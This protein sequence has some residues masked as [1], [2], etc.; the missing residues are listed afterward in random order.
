MPQT[1]ASRNALIQRL[2][3]TPQTTQR[4]QWWTGR[5]R[6]RT[7]VAPT[8]RAHPCPSTA[9]T[10]HPDHCRRPISIRSPAGSLLG[11]PQIAPQTSTGAPIRTQCNETRPTSTGTTQTRR[12]NQ[13]RAPIP[14]RPDQT[15]A[16][17]LTRSCPTRAQSAHLAWPGRAHLP[18]SPSAGAPFPH[19]DNANHP[20]EPIPLPP[21]ILQPT[22][23][24]WPRSES[25]IPYS[26]ELS[27]GPSSL[28]AEPAGGQL[29]G[30]WARMGLREGEKPMG[31]I[32]RA[33]NPVILEAFM[34][35]K[36]RGVPTDEIGWRRERGGPGG[37]RGVV[38]GPEGA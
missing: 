1:S 21:A 15:M 4:A 13:H 7:C 31:V 35:T 10:T 19:P 17:R 2:A 34:P 9:P 28:T 22:H 3:P 18:H 32:D 37:E 29:G 23:P 16:V 26:W 36:G 12:A 11:M 6:V 25:L 27:L 38:R 8:R 20:D 14:T 24:P 5:P 33:G 30:K